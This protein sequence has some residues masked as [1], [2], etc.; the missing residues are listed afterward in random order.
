[1]RISGKSAAASLYAQRSTGENSVS[2][3]GNSNAQIAT[4]ISSA[5]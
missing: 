1:M 3:Q 4:A 5:T 2:S